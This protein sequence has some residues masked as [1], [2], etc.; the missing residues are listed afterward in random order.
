MTKQEAIT[1]MVANVRE[2]RAKYGFPALADETILRELHEIRQVHGAFN[3]DVWL[4]GV[5]YRYMQY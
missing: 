1:K 5:F 2:A 3:N 4:C